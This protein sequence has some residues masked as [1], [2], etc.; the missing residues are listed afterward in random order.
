M[1]GTQQHTVPIYSSTQLHHPLHHP[2]HQ[3]PVHTKPHSSHRKYDSPSYTLQTF[4]PRPARPTYLAIR[5]LNVELARIPDTVS[6]PA[7]AAL[8]FQFWRD[9]IAHAFAQQ[10]PRAHPVPILLAHALATLP[11]TAHLSKSWLLRL[12]SAREQYSSNPPYADLAALE[13]YAESTYATLLY[14]TLSA[15]PLASLSADHLASHIGKAS[16][17][18]AVLRGV[19]LL[20][21]PPPPNHHSNRSGLVPS[22]VQHTS[23]RQ[24]AVTL[25]LDVMA[26]AG[27]REEDVLR[28][29]P[30]APGLRDAVFA[31][32]TRASDHLITAR[33]MLRNLRSGETAGHAYEHEGEDGHVYTIPTG[34]E[35]SPGGSQTGGGTHRAVSP[36]E[37][38]ELDIAFGVLM[39]AI[40]TAL[41]LERLEKVDF[42]IFRPE[43]RAREWKLPW[44]A[45]WAWRRKML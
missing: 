23:A 36:R 4:I 22:D 6:A 33:Q 18:V 25:P 34:A 13:A 26:E 10:P 11:T 43:L 45:Y 24:G 17:I 16:G 27:V 29:G 9:N 37:D 19:P 1:S 44:R 7:I 14:L 38:N 41:W 20:A 5:A 2:K 42:D 21:F 28:L 30:D 35:A 40:A 15:I 32:A 39:P 31:V 12:I 3:S 8:R